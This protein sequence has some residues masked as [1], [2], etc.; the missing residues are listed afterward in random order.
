MQSLLRIYHEFEKQLNKRK[1]NFVNILRRKNIIINNCNLIIIII[2]YLSFVNLTALSCTKNSSEKNLKK[3]TYFYCIMNKNKFLP[4]V[5]NLLTSNSVSYKISNKPPIP[6][7]NKHIKSILT[8]CCIVIVFHSPGVCLATHGAAPAK[9]LHRLRTPT[10]C[11]YDGQR[12]AA[13]CI[14]QPPCDGPYDNSHRGTI[15]IAT[16]CLATTPEKVNGVRVLI[17]ACFALPPPSAGGFFFGNV[18]RLAGKDEFC[19]PLSLFSRRFDKKRFAIEGD[20]VV[21]TPD[22]SNRVKMMFK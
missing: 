5:A 16:A 15:S 20:V 6:N 17:F 19:L 12:A 18:G 2:F 21:R 9:C 10:Q 22:A 1:N 3:K 11:E 13:R 7:R 4:Q 8:T 14:P